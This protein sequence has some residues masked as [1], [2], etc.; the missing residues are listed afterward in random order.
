MAEKTHL[1][2]RGLLAAAVMCS[3][4]SDDMSPQGDMPRHLAGIYCNSKESAQYVAGSLL[5]ATGFHGIHRAHVAMHLQQGRA[6]VVRASH[7]A[8][9]MYRS[10]MPAM[11][12]LWC[13]WQIKFVQHPTLFRRVPPVGEVVEVSLVSISVLSFVEQKYAIQDFAM[14]YVTGTELPPEMN[15]ASTEELMREVFDTKK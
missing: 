1:F 12:P 7:P 4:S 10:M 9:S 2:S 15:L 6:G 3:M 13:A 5:R 11:H 8:H 14:F